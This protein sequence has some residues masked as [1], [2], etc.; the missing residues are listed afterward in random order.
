MASRD[1]AILTVSVAAQLA[2]MHPQT[3]RQYD[4]LGLVP[5]RRTRGGGRR[6]SLADVDRLIEIQR[7][8]QEEGINLAGISR[9]IDLENDAAKLRR[10]VARLQKQVAQR[11]ELLERYRMLEHR[12][13]AAAAD[14][15]VVVVSHQEELR[16]RL[17]QYSSGAELV[18]WRP[19]L[20]A[21][22]REQDN[23]D[24]VAS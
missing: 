23:D 18:L 9:I 19:R 17:R 11:D 16:Q 1:A 14:G 15:D 22:R 3:L 13:F 7:L 21:R 2:G 5:A 12:V 8:S 20:P 6:Y 10:Q 24:Q 4:R